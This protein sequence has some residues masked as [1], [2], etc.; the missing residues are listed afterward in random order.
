MK[1]NTYAVRYESLLENSPCFFNDYF[2][3]DQTL[4]VFIRDL[5]LQMIEKVFN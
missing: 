3:Y 2:D 4:E 1:T 5:G